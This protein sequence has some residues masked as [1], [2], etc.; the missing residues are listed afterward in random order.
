MRLK[1][2]KRETKLQEAIKRKWDLMRYSM[3]FLPRLG[4]Y[5]SLLKCCTPLK[6]RG[7]G[8]PAR[9]EKR[10]AKSQPWYHWCRGCS[11]ILPNLFQIVWSLRWRNS[12]YFLLTKLTAHMS[13]YSS[14]GVAFYG[15]SRIGPRMSQIWL[16][17]VC[18]KPEKEAQIPKAGSEMC[19]WDVSLCRGVVSNMFL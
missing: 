6:I 19:G 1:R 4:I 2:P 9:R 16:D 12:P 14:S 10:Q 11:K 7:K 18:A 13:T 5:L 15:C 8:C 17:E 3:H